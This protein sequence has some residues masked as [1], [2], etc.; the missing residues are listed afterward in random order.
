MEVLGFTGK[1]D[2][3]TYKGDV[4]ISFVKLTGDSHFETYKGKIV[5]DVPKQTGFALRT[6]FEK[7]VHFNSTFDVNSH[8]HGRKHHYYYD[9]SGTINGGGPTLNFSSTKGDI[10]LR[11]D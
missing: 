5:V 10:H 6:D 8:E 1:A 9:Y 4:R 2:V 3:D 11:A 7:H